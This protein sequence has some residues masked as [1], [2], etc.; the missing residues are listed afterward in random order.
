M[1]TDRR[2]GRIEHYRRIAAFKLAVLGYHLMS[3]G[4]AIFPHDKGM[5]VRVLN[6]HLGGDND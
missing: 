4:F 1:G 5:L 6:R 2:S 3:L